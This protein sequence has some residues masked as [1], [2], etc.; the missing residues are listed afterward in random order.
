[1]T[2]AS[3][4][5]LR[6]QIVDAAQQMTLA[7]HSPG[8]SGNVSARMPSGFLI[9]PTGAEAGELTPDDVVALDAEGAPLRGPRKPSTEWPMHAALYATRPEVGAVVHCHSRFA[10]ILSCTRRGIPA[11]HYMVAVTGGFDVPCAPYA[12]FGTRALSDAICGAMGE[13]SA[14]LMANHGQIA[15]GPDLRHAVRMAEEVERLAETWWGVLAIGDPVLL[16]EDEMRD[17]RERFESGYGQPG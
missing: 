12:T 13:R 3:Q 8:T 5:A 6:Q 9:T 15:V 14:C 2:R 16:S 17:A 1:M 7:G 11:I 4:D 10:T